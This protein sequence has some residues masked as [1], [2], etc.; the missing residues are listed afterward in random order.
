MA[1][2]INKKR[3]IEIIVLL[4]ICLIFI[5]LINKYIINGI[6]HRFNISS[7]LH[8]AKNKVTDISRKK[9]VECEIGEVRIVLPDGEI[10][11]KKIYDNSQKDNWL[12]I[13]DTY[14][15]FSHGKASIYDF[16]NEGGMQVAN[17]Y[18]KNIIAIDRFEPITVENFTW[19]EDPY[20]NRYWRFIYYS[21]REMRHL[22]YAY[23]KTGDGKY[24]NKLTEIV[25]SF[26]DTNKE[27]KNAWDDYHSVAFRTMSL[28]NIWWKL[29]EY[30]VLSVEL[31]KKILK[32]I[33]EHGEFLLEEAHYEGGHNHGISQAA[34]LMLVGVNFPD[35][36]NSKKYI[37]IAKYRLNSGIQ[38]IIDDDGVLI[39]NS[40]FYHFYAL[41][42]YWSIKKYLLKNNLEVDVNYD[43][44][45]RDM[46]SYAT[47]I[48]QPDLRVP[49]MGASLDRYVGNS[50]V[51]A[52]IA[53]EYPSFLYVLTNGSEG[54]I[55]SDLSRYYPT[56]GKVIM[57]SAWKSRDKFE[58][59]F[60]NQ[61]HLVFD[62]GEYRTNHSDLDA[63]S[64][65]LYGNGKALVVDTGLYTY[66]NSNDL[67]N[68]FHGTMGH[69]TVVVDGLSQRKG[70]TMHNK[71]FKGENFV[72]HSSQHDLYSQ[73]HHQRNITLLGK[74]V[75][76]IVDRLFSRGE[77]DYEQLFHLF[78]GA[79]VEIEDNGKVV[80]KNENKEIELTIHQMLTDNIETKSVS[81]DD[82]KDLGRC[83]LQYGKMISCE[84][85]HFKKHGKTASFVTVLEIGN[86]NKEIILKMI[87]NNLLTISDDHKK[88]NFNINEKD[89]KFVEESISREVE[90]SNYEFA[91]NK[92]NGKW[93]IDG[94]ENNKYTVTNQNGNIT[95]GLTDE[96]NSQ[97]ESPNKSYFEANF[98]G[99]D[100]YHS[101]KNKIYT[102]IPFDDRDYFRVYE[103]ED[104]LPILGYHHILPDDKDITFSHLEIHV[105]DFDKQIAY[106]TNEMGCRWFTF[107]EIIEKYVRKEKKIPK[108]ACILN[109]DDGYKDHYTLGYNTFKKYGAV[110]T[111]YSI[112]KNNTI[113][114]SN[115]INIS[116][117]N[118]LIDNGN[119]IGSHTVNSSGLLT[120]EYTREELIYQLSESKKM[121]NRLGYNTK[122]FAYPRGEQNEEI[123][124][125][126]SE[127]YLAGRDTEKDNTWREARSSTV[128]FDDDYLWHMHYH[129]PEMESVKEL[130][131]AIWYNNWWQF[132]EGFKFDFNFEGKGRLLS[133]Y[134]P[135]E[136][137]YAVVSLTS[138]GDKISNKFTVRKDS[139]YKIEFLTSFRN[140]APEELDAVI[141]VFVNDKIQELIK[142]DDKCYKAKNRTFCLYQIDTYLKEGVNVLSVE[143]V[144]KGVL[145]DKFQVYRLIKTKKSY[146]F[147]IKELKKLNPRKYP[148]PI[149]VEIISEKR[150]FPW[151]MI[152]GGFILGTIIVLVVIYL[153][154]K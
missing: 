35:F 36:P 52:E 135:T 71:F 110:A 118:D 46:I 131:K 42:K 15:K 102:D 88:Y 6:E 129:K 97:I 90:V 134:K 144:F 67:K 78:A 109:F 89:E 64:F 21:L 140:D 83:S 62:V 128:S 116:E 13:Y 114:K 4:S 112:I 147:F 84:T 153:R 152:S 111:F 126:V 27:K 136:N 48:L 39:E 19:E 85:I 149:V 145:L 99:I 117:M 3:I 5:A 87:N 107:G 104:F 45:L 150:I 101:R 38:N 100:N 34:A 113:E 12:K 123:V 29:R 137:S 93:K 91:L 37:D 76:V 96:G 23:N 24:L 132:E 31:S 146:N 51:F 40:P 18:M 73:V 20:N 94:D 75:I 55:P 28:V 61:T 11:R 86:G 56:A 106:M 143:A 8:L 66:D 60:K 7:K 120:D 41:E 69:N 22:I 50:G 115:S 32:S 105:S 92:I 63:L 30:N 49:L 74:D 54:E 1:Q 130:K 72:T 57:R 70:S 47:Y 43:K 81:A 58:N 59:E 103:Q 133:S 119:E 68:Y 65:N 16:M 138:V 25:E 122:T 139:K 141:K 108:N 10:C 53:K 127:F 154:K 17:K 80:V 79:I 95:I 151:K 14:P 2:R 33:E 9:T 125:L 142:T 124:D 26:L 98:D 148:E 77:H 121:I 82:N 44:K